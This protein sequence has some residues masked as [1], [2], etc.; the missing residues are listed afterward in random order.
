VATSPVHQSCA[1]AQAMTSA[2]SGPSL[3]YGWKAP[4]ESPRPRTSTMAQ[5]YPALASIAARWEFR[6]PVLPYGV[7]TTTVGAGSSRGSARSA[8]SVTPSRNGIRTLNLRETPASITT[9][10]VTGGRDSH[11]GGGEHRRSWRRDAVAILAGPARDAG[12]G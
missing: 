7:R 12:T 1:A 4:S 10:D 5:A 3:R 2:P 11:G 9:P 6:S 8:D